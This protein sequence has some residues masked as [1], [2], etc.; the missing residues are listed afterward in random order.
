MVQAQANTVA[1]SSRKATPLQICNIPNVTGKYL[2]AAKRFV[3]QEAQNRRGAHPQTRRYSNL[4]RIE[5][6]F[7]SGYCRRDRRPG[8]VK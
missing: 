1:I 7:P 3:Y 5:L 8:R 2:P 4:K 6:N